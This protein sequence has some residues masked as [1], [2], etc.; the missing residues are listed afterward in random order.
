MLDYNTEKCPKSYQPK[1]RYMWVSWNDYQFQDT[2]FCWLPTEILGQ[3]VTSASKYLFE[4]MDNEVSQ[5]TL[6]VMEEFHH[7]LPKDDISPKE[8]DPTYKQ[9][10]Y[11]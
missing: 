6:K 10:L 2:M 11:S 9:I 3:S 5:L 7:L 1:E 4:Y 8:Q